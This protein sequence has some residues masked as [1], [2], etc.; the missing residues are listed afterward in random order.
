MTDFRSKLETFLSKLVEIKMESSVIN[1]YVDMSGM[2]GVQNILTTWSSSYPSQNANIT[3]TV[4]VIVNNICRELITN[5]QKNRMLNI[6]DKF[7]LNHNSVQMSFER[8][9]RML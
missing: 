8:P 6:I 9:D 3:N 4:T 5:E 1:M 7:V 2:E